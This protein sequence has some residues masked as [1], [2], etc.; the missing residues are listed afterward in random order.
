MRAR[1]VVTRSAPLHRPQDPFFS[2]NMHLNYGDLAENVK[3]LLEAF[4][5]KTQSSKASKRSHQSLA[6]TRP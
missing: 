2:E 3:G 1:C 4:Q 6:T 5:A